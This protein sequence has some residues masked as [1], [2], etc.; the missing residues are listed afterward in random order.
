MANFSA[1]FTQR[2]V[3]GSRADIP[4]SVGVVPSG[5]AFDGGVVSTFATLSFGSAPF[6]LAFDGSG[7]LYTA[8]D[9]TN[10][11]KKIAP[12]GVVSN[13]ANLPASSAPW[14]LAFDGSGNLYVSNSGTD[15]ISKITP[16]GSVSTFATLSAISAVAGMAFDNSG[17][18]YVVQSIVNRIEKITPG[19]SVSTFVNLV[20]DNAGPQGL[21]FDSSDNAFYLAE[22]N[23]GKIK[24]ITLAGA[25]T[26]F[27]SYDAGYFLAIQ[28][29]PEPGSVGVVFAFALGSVA[30]LRRAPHRRLA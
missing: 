6:G 30:L 27:A 8:N 26:D 21:V 29:V 25:Q 12:G 10:R 4:K 24:K 11:I 14:G 9:G 1:G 5:L 23:A 18:L 17:N 16:G 15:K 13:F 7:N 19:G 28:P 20:D 22:S 3:P 2:Q